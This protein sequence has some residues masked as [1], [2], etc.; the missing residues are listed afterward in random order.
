MDERIRKRM[1]GSIW[2]LIVGDA[3]GVPVE[4][5]DRDSLKQKPVTDMREYGTHYQP[6]GTWS[7]DTSMMLGTMDSL[8]GGLDYADIMKRFS[9]WIFYD[10]Y[11]PHGV[12][13]DAGMAVSSALG[14]Y[15][16]GT[17]LKDCGG[18]G[19]WDNGNGSLMRILPVALYQYVRYN[20]FLF[21][22]RPAL[23]NPIHAASA[24]THANPVSMI[25]CGL[26]SHLIAD[27][28]RAAGEAEEGPANW[29]KASWNDYDYNGY[30]NIYEDEDYKEALNRYERLRDIEKF[31]ALPE[32]E[33]RSGGYVVDT[34][35]AAVWCLLNTG[36]FEECVLKAVNLGAD[37]DTV[38]AVAG[39]LAGAKYGLD[40]IPKEW[41]ECLARK[42]WIGELT[43][44]FL[45]KLTA[46]ASDRGDLSA[47]K[48]AFESIGWRW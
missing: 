32:E 1:E 38:G 3:L 31:R 22:N 11:T 35:E 28:L 24:L 2:G 34:L 14:R 40:S 21:N 7:D 39:S 19:A 47:E 45:E 16:E 4:F 44:R 42:E 18:R 36:S 46:L 20:G 43:G 9:D 26:Y 23:L 5:R 37:T 13:F 33:I 8:C 29:P 6:Q 25:G 41:L 30:G 10:M 27:L 12:V 48:Q 15:E 17:A